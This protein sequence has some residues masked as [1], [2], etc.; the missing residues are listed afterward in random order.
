VLCTL[1][2]L[3]RITA[4]WAQSRDFLAAFPLLPEALEGAANLGLSLDDQVLQGIS[5]AYVLSRGLGF[6]AAVELALKLKETSGI[7]AEAFSTA[8]VRHG[9]REIVD[10][11]FLVVALGIPGSG[12]EDVAKAAAELESQGARVLLI[13]PVELG[14]RFALPKA[15][16]NRLAPLLAL[17]MLY[18]WIARSAQALGRNP[19]QPKVL[20]TKIV[21]T[22]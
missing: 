9:P 3:A 14:S 6:G 2:S 10:K 17:Q 8:E 22:V 19:D 15:P 7:H 11:K 5:H 12:A 4:E 20:K 16:D 1:A 18:P 21:E 13:G